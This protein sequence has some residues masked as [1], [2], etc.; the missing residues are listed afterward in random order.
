M[1]N[2]IGAWEREAQ[3]FIVDTSSDYQTCTLM[4]DTLEDEYKIFEKELIEKLSIQINKVRNC[5]KI[6]INSKFIFMCIWDYSIQK[7]IVF[8]SDLFQENDTDYICNL[9]K[10]F[11][12][13]SIK[14]ASDGFVVKSINPNNRLLDLAFLSRCQV[15]MLSRNLEAQNNNKK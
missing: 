8:C 12:D 9:A 10:Q 13:I 15:E 2:K 3:M 4:M 11:I 7:Y 14:C 5:L 1:E 6:Q